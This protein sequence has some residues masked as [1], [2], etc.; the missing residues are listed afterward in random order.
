M[1]E[2]RQ[3]WGVDTFSDVASDEEPWSDEDDEDLPRPVARAPQPP[4]APA[5]DSEPGKAAPEGSAA[6]PETDAQL[7]QLQ[8]QAEQ[9]LKQQVTLELLEKTELQQ[10]TALVG[11]PP[12]HYFWRTFTLSSD[13]DA[14]EHQTSIIPTACEPPT[15][16][17]ET[18]IVREVLWMLQGLDNAVLQVVCLSESME[19]KKNEKKKKNKKKKKK[20]RSKG[21]EKKKNAG[22]WAGPEATFSLPCSIRHRSYAI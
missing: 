9:S 6:I 21:E 10:R 7:L 22:V 5:E 19:M 18:S 12:D 16:R 14:F 11:L 2:L 13:W 17:S 1:D 8:I 4:L 15:L 20:Q 3:G